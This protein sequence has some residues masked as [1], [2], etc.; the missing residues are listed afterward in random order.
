MDADPEPT[1]AR[2]TTP[3]VRGVLRRGSFWTVF[4]FLL[5]LVVVLG[6]LLRGAG[7]A[8]GGVLEADNPAPRGGMAVAEVLESR[9]IDVR[10]A[11]TLEE[12]RDAVAD[13]ADTTVLFYDADGLL[14]DDR[15]DQVGDLAD[16]LVLVDPD[17]TALAEL[18]PGVL[19]AGGAG[20]DTAIAAGCALPVASAAR[21]LPA[22]DTGT[23][24][25]DDATL[26]D[27]ARVDTCFGVA[28]EAFALVRVESGGRS[29]TV[30][31]GDPL[32]TNDG[33]IE[34]G[35]AALALGLLG[36]SNTLVWYIPTLGDVEITGP[37]PL[38]ELT[39]GWVTPLILLALVVTLAAAIWRGRRFGPLVIENLPVIVRASE[40]VEGRA[41]LY[42]RVSARGRALDALRIGTISRIATALRLAR[43]AS[44]DEVVAACAAATGMQPADVHAVL[45]GELPRTDRDLVSLSDRLSTLEAAVKSAVDPTGSRP[46]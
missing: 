30:V 40:T 38:G 15:L 20:T 19:L 41:R 46:T 25:V 17:F 24:R 13:A 7:G 21:T 2:A 36:S 26:G 44:V 35:S 42:G 28:D 3:T 6:V 4:A 23:Y 32:L 31:D 45:I 39:P 10:T 16:D 8:I 22:E 29:V 18:A 27:D 33:V 1:T 43:T 11:G 34:R 14:A 12:A 5:L 37:P 9:G